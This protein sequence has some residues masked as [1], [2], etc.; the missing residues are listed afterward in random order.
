MSYSPDAD[1]KQR[2]PGIQWIVCR[3]LHHGA[4]ATL[5]VWVLEPGAMLE[6]PEFLNGQVLEGMLVVTSPTGATVVTAGERLDSGNPDGLV[7]VRKSRVMVSFS[8]PRSEFEEAY[9]AA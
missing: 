1:L 4:P 6:A 8:P 3:R 5:V 7:S 2:S 9:A